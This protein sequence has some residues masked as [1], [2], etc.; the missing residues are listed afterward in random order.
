MQIVFHIGAHATD[1]GKLL[2]SL[3]RSKSILAG[4]GVAVT[5][6]GRY[7]GL[8]QE[9]LARLDDA[10][11][12]PD[13][14][15]VLLDAILDEDTPDRVILSNDSFICFPGQILAEQMFY[16]A[17]TEK[18]MKLVNLFPDDQLEFFLALRNPAGFIPAAHELVPRLSFEQFLRGT[19]PLHLRWSHMVRRIREAAPQATVTVWCNEDTPLIWE[20]LLHALAST[21]PATELNGIHDLLEEIMT[22]EGMQRMR[23]FIQKNPPRSQARKQRIIEAFLD[24]FA[25]QD[26]LE[27]ELDAPGWTEQLVSQLTDIYEAD[28]EDIRQMQGVRFIAP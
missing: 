11:P 25:R 21:D 17:T 5:G 28:V 13:A 26:I 1:Q 18:I 24:K 3:F 9:T 4:R 10:Q 22:R 15:D 7:R 12:A 19:N 16:A 6:P 27:E 23:G 20:R 14:R 2:K 8:L